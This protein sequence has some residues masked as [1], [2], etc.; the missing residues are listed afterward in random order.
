M[1]RVMVNVRKKSSDLERY[2][3]MMDLQ[4]RNETLFF[5]TLLDAHDHEPNADLLLVFS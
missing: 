5:R 2:M 1:V 3:F 4:D